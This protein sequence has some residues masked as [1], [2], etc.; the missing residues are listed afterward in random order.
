MKS[1]I[2]GAAGIL[3][4][5]GALPAFAADMAVAEPPVE[6]PIVETAGVYDWGGFY[7][8]ANTGYAWTHGDYTGGGLPGDHSMNGWALGAFAGYNFF[9]NGWVYGVEA[10]VKH[11]FN[12]DRF[13]SGDTYEYETTWG[14]SVRARLGYAIDRTLIYGTGG[15]AFTN[16]KVTNVTTGVNDKETF[17]GWTIGAGVEHAFT[18]NLAGRIEYRYTDYKKSDVFG[19]AGS[20]G[21]I[22]SHS[23]MLG[24]SMKF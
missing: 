15:Y 11:D 13:T 24:V 10:D 5:A 23:L 2:F 9:N 21:K 12:N 22:D 17:H 7:V 3:V 14:G 1:M 6:T 19:V 8:G 16:A 18:D 4:T 20:D